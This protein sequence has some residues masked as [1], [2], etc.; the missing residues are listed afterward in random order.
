MHQTLEKMLEMKKSQGK[1]VPFRISESQRHAAM[2]KF[3]SQL[4][5]Y[6]KKSSNEPTVFGGSEDLS[7]E[8]LE[9]TV[10]ALS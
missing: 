8:Q 5:S 4:Q 10:L 2:T 3:N 7:E 6:V 9:Q 1:Q